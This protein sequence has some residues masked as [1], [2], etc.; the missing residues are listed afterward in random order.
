M[1][2]WNDTFTVAAVPSAVRL[3]FSVAALAVT[4][5]ASSVVTEGGS[6]EVVKRCSSPLLMPYCPPS[7]LA[8]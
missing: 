1:P 4:P 6:A 3:P 7:P 2:Y 5:P 8:R